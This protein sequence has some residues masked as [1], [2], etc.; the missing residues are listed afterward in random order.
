L[1]GGKEHESFLKIPPEIAASV[2][3]GE[4]KRL[5][6]AGGWNGISFTRAG[7][8]NTPYWLRYEKELKK[9]YNVTCPL[10]NHGPIDPRWMMF[11]TKMDAENYMKSLPADRDKSLNRA[12]RQVWAQVRGQF[13]MQARDEAWDKLQTMKDDSLKNQSAYQFRDRSQVIVSAIIDGY[14]ETEWYSYF[15][16][17][18]AIWEAGYGVLGD[19]AGVFYVY[20][21]L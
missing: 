4:M 7:S 13:R 8:N 2:N 14:E 20:K 16:K 17:R 5:A 15:K 18:L 9:Y 11:D 10:D 19:I 6:K 1:S 3:R 21:H 12:V